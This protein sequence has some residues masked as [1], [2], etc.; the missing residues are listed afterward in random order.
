MSTKTCALSFMQ[1]APNADALFSV[2]EGVKSGNALEF[3]SLF[4]NSVVGLLD[5][6]DGIAPENRTHITESACYLAQMAKA[7]I[8]SIEV[9]E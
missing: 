8:D 5:M 1:L 2:N 6:L 3:A 4:L 7:A 9:A